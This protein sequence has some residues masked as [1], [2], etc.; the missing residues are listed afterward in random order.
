MARSQ[1]YKTFCFKL[2]YFLED[3][4]FHNWK[5]VFSVTLKWPSLKKSTEQVYKK[6]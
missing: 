2:T 4:S 5:H 6:I 1:T 3:T